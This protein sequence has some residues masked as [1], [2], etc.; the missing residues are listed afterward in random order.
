VKPD[1][2]PDAKRPYEPPR[3]TMVKIR[4]DEVVLAACK[5]GG[6]GGSPAA[7]CLMGCV[8]SGS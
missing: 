8:V 6:G 3:L 1:E 2:K 7:S 5:T 4:V